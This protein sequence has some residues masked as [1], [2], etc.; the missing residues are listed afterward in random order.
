MK[1][2]ELLRQTIARFVDNEFI[3]VAR[4]IDEKEE[5]P[6][7]MFRKLAK[8]GT[9][10]I[11]YP[12]EYGGSGGN[13]TMFCI[14][15]EELARGSIA[16]AA[17]TAMQCLMGTDFIFRY[18]TEEHKRRL[19]IPAIKGEKVVAFALTEPEAGTDLAGVRTTATRTDDGYII[20]G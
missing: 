16:V 2:E 19:L 7:E 18:G 9:F 3:P 20:N 1:A 10:G 8:L 6:W 15:C 17:F 13:T 14:M 11:R 5:F 12:K 4:E